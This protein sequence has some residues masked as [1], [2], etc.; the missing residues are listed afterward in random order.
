MLKMAVGQSDDVDPAVAVAEAIEQCR[1]QLDGL[2]PRAGILFVA[3]DSF[4]PS[5]QA[6]V[7][8]AF[9]GVNLIGSTSAA[10]MTSEIG[11]RED[12]VALTLFATDE[13]DATVGFGDGLD[14]DPAAAA[15]AALN[16]ALAGT[17]REPKVCIVLTEPLSGQHAIEALR[18]GLPST[19][20]I[21]G[22]AAGRHDLGG[23]TPTYQFCNDHVSPDG[24]AVL[25]LAGPVAYSAAVGM[26]WRTLG[27]QGIVTRSDYGAIDEIDG[28]PAGE[29]ASSYLDLTGPGALGNPLA[30]QDPG[31]TGWY[32]R[33]VLAG[34]EHGSLAIP[35]GVPVGAT[36]QL[37]TTS[38]D[39]M[40]A[41]TADALTRARDSFP[42]A[43][44][45]SGALIFSCA[46]RK[47]LLGTRT[48]E[49]VESAR[50]ILPASLPIA[51]MYCVGEI[52]PTGTDEASHFLNETFVTLL[53]GE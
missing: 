45:P 7:R 21:V 37:T 18:A 4:D 25:V 47:F 39:Q 35:G 3:Q 53:L 40:L 24:L 20:L 12:S 22:G 31:S 8:A 6:S 36:V 14:T 51:G 42:A 41:A 50:D 28:K 52:A 34:A 44:T 27:P 5:L 17:E 32:L 23:Q 43:S 2:A 10:E 13:V 16:E 1:A 11:Y 15:R 46:V 30:I 9:P 33:V 26:G 49:E 19:V 48:D 29:W 38:P